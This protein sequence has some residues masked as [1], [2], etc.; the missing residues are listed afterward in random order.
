MTITPSLVCGFVSWFEQPCSKK[1]GVRTLLPCSLTLWNS[2]LLRK[3]LDFSKQESLTYELVA[4]LSKSSGNGGTQSFTT[5]KSS[6]PKDFSA[7]ACA[8]AFMKATFAGTFNL[9]GLVGRFHS[10][11]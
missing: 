5:S 7:C 10:P 2:R 11:C 8:V 9:G 6:I 3:R 4:R 1:Y